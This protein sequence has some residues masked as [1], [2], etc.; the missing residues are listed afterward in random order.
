MA[1]RAFITGVSGTALTDDERAFLRA[2]RP[3]GFILFKRNI[4]TP[5]QVIRLVQELRASVGRLDAPVLIDQDDAG[6]PGLE[7]AFAYLLGDIDIVP[8]LHRRESRSQARD[9]D[10]GSFKPVELVA[11]PLCRQF[12]FRRYPFRHPLACELP[13]RRTLRGHLIVH[14]RIGDRQ[15]H[16]DAQP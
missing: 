13:N 3:W 9:R 16:A 8:A 10:Q 6:H 7:H 14:F 11:E 15:Q 5:D 12:N 2:Q 1:A 4:E